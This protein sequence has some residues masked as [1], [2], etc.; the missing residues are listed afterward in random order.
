MGR[1]GGG[2][3]DAPGCAGR[4]FSLDVT[5]LLPYLY[6]CFGKQGLEDVAE[7]LVQA[8]HFER[9]DTLA[10][11]RR[12]EVGRAGSASPG[13]EGDPA[14]DAHVRELEELERSL[15]R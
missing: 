13:E 2:S 8:R 4:S 1:R 6:E 3:A 11:K 7:E 5:K 10:G 9:L 12:P 15:R 14:V